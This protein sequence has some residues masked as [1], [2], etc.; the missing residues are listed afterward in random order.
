[1]IYEETIEDTATVSLNNSIE[2]GMCEDSLYSSSL[3]QYKKE[4]FIFNYINSPMK[5]YNK[6]DAMHIL[7]EMYIKY[8]ELRV[9]AHVSW[10]T[11]LSNKAMSKVVEM[12]RKG[13]ITAVDIVFNADH[14]LTSSDAPPKATTS[15][16]RF[17]FLGKEFA[18]LKFYSPLVGRTFQIFFY[19][20]YDYIKDLFYKESYIY[21]DPGIYTLLESSG[22]YKAVKYMSSTDTIDDIILENNLMDNVFGDLEHFRKNK[23]FYEANSL[24]YRRGIL[25]YGKPGNGKTLFIKNV[26]KNYNKEEVYFMVIPCDKGFSGEKALFLSKCFPKNAFKIFIFEDVDSLMFSEGM[27]HYNQNRSPFLNFI[28]GIDSVE[29]TFI[30]ATTNYPEA[31]DEAGSRYG[32]FDTTYELTL[33]KAAERRKFLL[34]YFP[35][36]LSPE[37]LEVLIKHTNG[38]SGVC[39]R[40]LFILV[41]IKGITI[42]KAIEDIQKRME[43]HRDKNFDSSKKRIGI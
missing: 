10:D 36:I 5:D 7:E 21:P 26:I 20:D 35:G 4:D 43:L 39:F 25:L 41:G 31:L 2:A 28:E 30:I 33:P 24:P 40:E 37:R 3:F 17:L 27:G 12:Q 13:D 11:K 1:M 18:S 22:E 16:N 6:W 34:K 32:R 9:Y 42:E 23:A 15:Y 19:N 29:N 14:F 38:F 8:P